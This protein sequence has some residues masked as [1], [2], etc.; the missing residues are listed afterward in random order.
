MFLF[1]QLRYIELIVEISILFRLQKIMT[2]HGKS[3]TN[4][5]KKILIMKIINE[6]VKTIVTTGYCL[7]S[8]LFG[9]NLI[10]RLRLHV[11]P[12]TELHPKHRTALNPSPRLVRF[13]SRTTRA[14]A[15]QIF[16]TP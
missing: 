13:I 5:T 3:N 10:I 4:F 12:T 16:S 14:P 6:V 8:I 1:L 2:E 15:I 11:V 9:P 7:H